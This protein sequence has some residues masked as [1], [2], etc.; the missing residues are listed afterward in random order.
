MLVLEIKEKVKEN[1]IE[2]E[3]SKNGKDDY[4]RGSLYTKTPGGKSSD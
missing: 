1:K 4:V 3:K 2:K